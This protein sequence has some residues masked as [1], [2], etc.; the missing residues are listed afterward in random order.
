MAESVST[1]KKNMLIYLSIFFFI[2]LTSMYFSESL[3]E[4]ECCCL[5]VSQGITSPQAQVPFISMYHPCH[6]NGCTS[7]DG[8]GY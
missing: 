7:I 4:L 8:P 3:H 5:F 1:F 6:P 2:H